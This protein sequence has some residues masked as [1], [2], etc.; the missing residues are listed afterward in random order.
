MGLIRINISLPRDIVAELSRRLPARKR[1]QFI[2]EA[3]RRHLKDQ[4]ARQL[5]AEYAEAA[6]EIRRLNQ[7]LEGTLNDGLD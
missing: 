3:V 2:S 4:M 6:E 5:A 7:D 1:S